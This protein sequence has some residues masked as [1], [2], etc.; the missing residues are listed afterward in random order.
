MRARRA[1]RA[2]VPPRSE[3]LADRLRRFA[4]DLRY[5]PDGPAEKPEPKTAGPASKPEAEPTVEPVSEPEP[6]TWSW[7][8][9]KRAEPEAKSKLSAT[10]LG[11]SSR[12]GDLGRSRTD[13][14]RERAASVR[15]AG[16]GLWARIPLGVRQRLVAGA[17]LLAVVALIVFVVAPIAPCWVPGGDRCTP[18][19]E[20]IAMV[21]ADVLAYGHVNLGTDTDEYEDA[22]ALAEQLPVL[23]ADALAALPSATGRLVDYDRDV[24]PWSGGEA[25]LVVDSQ[26]L[27]VER[28]LMFEVEDADAAEEF[29]RSRLRFGAETSFVDGV[30]ISVDSDGFAFAI[31]DDFM[32][33]GPEA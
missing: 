15:S 4:D 19:D 2:A 17:A 10:P 13:S 7:P 8:S 3:P 21:P 31:E 12:L 24:R 5:G 6:D 1:A 33:L 22:S 29:G 23:A 11:G 18:D 9:S 26:G 32:L 20:A 25:A 30:E 14:L 16:T 27:E 28:L